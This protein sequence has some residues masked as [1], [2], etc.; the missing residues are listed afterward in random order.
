MIVLGSTAHL[1]SLKRACAD[2]RV[3]FV[4]KVKRYMH[5]YGLYMCGASRDRNSPIHTSNWT[6]HIYISFHL[7]E[8]YLIVKSNLQ[9]HNFASLE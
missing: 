5:I 7:D 6:F 8:S 2:T 1:E 4:R 3:W 9:F